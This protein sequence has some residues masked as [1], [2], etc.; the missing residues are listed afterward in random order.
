VHFLFN[1]FSEA[2]DRAMLIRVIGIGSPF[3]DDAIGLEI[4]QILAQSPPA[5]CEVIVADRPG[6]GLI[7]WLDGVDGAILIDAV[8][9][10]ARPGTLHELSFEE[11]EHSQAAV[12]S[13]NEMGGAAAVRL[14]R[15]LGRVPLRG[16]L[17]GVEIGADSPLVPGPLSGSVRK[18]VRL[19][20]LKVHSWIG[21][22]RA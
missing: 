14:A 13:S 4:A 16:G 5:N 3:G 2:E 21:N 9:S 6:A 15:K 12:T 10:G 1:A 18:S 20:L 17:I 11:L 19:I 22:L 7:E 8:R